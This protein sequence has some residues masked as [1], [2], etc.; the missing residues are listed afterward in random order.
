[1]SEVK[2]VPQSWVKSD[3][4]R[5]VIYIVGAAL[6]AVGVA[7]GWITEEQ[8]AQIVTTV[9]NVLAI[10]GL[11]LAAANKPKAEKLLPDEAYETDTDAAE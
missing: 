4:A 6:L 11:S 9:T 7:V 1:M 10:F 2:E 3:T 8:S 5:Q